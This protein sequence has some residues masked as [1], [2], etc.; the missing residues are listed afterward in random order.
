MMPSA[1]AGAAALSVTSASAASIALCPPIRRIATFHLNSLSD[2]LF[3]LPA[4][5]AL[6]EGFPSAHISAVL[7]PGLAALLEDSPLINEVLPRPKGGVSTQAAL[8]ARLAAHHFDIA[9]AFSQSRQVSLLAFATRA[10]VRLGYQ[11]AK[12]E[13]L[14]THHIAQEG[15]FTVD[16]ALQFVRALGCPVQQ[17]D[18]CGLI[19]PLPS[20]TKVADALLEANQISGDFILAVCAGVDKK[21]DRRG[22]GEWP[23]E[24]W[25]A[26]LRELSPRWPVVLA[27]GRAVPEIRRYISENALDLGGKTSL[28]VL[29]ALCGKARLVI[30]ADG[31][32]LHL[33]AAMK[34]PVVGIYGPTD[35]HLTGPRGVSH[36]IVRLP[37]ECAPCLLTRCKWQGDDAQ[38]CMT[39]LPPRQVAQAVRELIGV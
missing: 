15:P 36:R 37:L 6:R 24:H 34:T 4:L 29:A 16:A 38:K 1:T 28:P 13:A 30:G 10:P 8:M 20:A 19:Q 31:G 11:G 25:I 12:M 3:S 27:G 26:T 32:V 22:L 23:A 33:A 35:S 7:R 18:Y 5:H 2:L 14:L 39:Q 21:Y 17:Y 9:L